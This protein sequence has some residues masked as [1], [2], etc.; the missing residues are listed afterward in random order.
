MPRCILTAA[1]T[2]ALAV[3]ALVCAQMVR[4]IDL[5]SLRGDVVFGQAPDLTLNGQAVRLAPG[6]RIRDTQNMLV[7]SAGLTGQKRTVNYT[8]D[9]YGLLMNVWLLTD[10]DIAQPWPKT[11]LEAATWAYDP[12]AHIWIKP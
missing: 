12:V 5:K 3:P 7:L 9:P 2:L 4:P 6:A 11:P 10:A 8:L 1:A